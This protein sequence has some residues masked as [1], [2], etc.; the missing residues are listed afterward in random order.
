MFDAVATIRSNRIF[1]RWI[2]WQFH[3]DA[4]MALNFKIGY[5]V[6][7]WAGDE[8]Q[9][10]NTQ[11]TPATQMSSKW[12]IV[13]C[14][15]F[16][17]YDRNMVNKNPTNIECS[18]VDD[19]N[20]WTDTFARSK[21]NFQYFIKYWG[22]SSSLHG[23]A[24]VNGIRKRF[25]H[26]HAQRCTPFKAHKMQKKRCKTKWRQAQNKRIMDQKQQFE[27]ILLQIKILRQNR[28]LPT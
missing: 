10:D 15:L 6:A 3:V 1:K 24:N 28:W 22:C 4:T 27:S 16:M 26:Y 12:V 9:N 2:L 19:G 11:K 23:D 13:E 8:I 18:D 14:L 20:K 25:S 7:E 17:R 21:I 5:T